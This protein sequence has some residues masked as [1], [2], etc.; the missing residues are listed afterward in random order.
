MFPFCLNKIGF[1]RLSGLFFRLSQPIF[2]NF[3]LCFDSFHQN[4]V[5]LDFVLDL[6][7]VFL[8][9]NWVCFDFI[10]LCFDFLYL[11][12]DFLDLGI[13]FLDQ[14]PVSFDFCARPMFRLSQPKSG[15]FR[16]Y[17]LLF[18]LPL[19]VFW[20]SWLRYYFS[21]PKSG[22]FRVLCSTYVSIFSIYYLTFSI[23]F[24][25]SSTK[26][27]SILSFVSDLSKTASRQRIVSGRKQ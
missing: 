24:L 22:M 21:G 9:Q 12:F 11:C 10:D 8:N 16:L 26:I 7:F 17:W 19:P 15:L 5:C 25:T 20:L 14:N 13:V 3:Y 23:C 1:I 27:G 6:L 4:R 2:D 18:R